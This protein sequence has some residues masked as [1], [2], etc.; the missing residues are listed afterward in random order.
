M[1]SFERVLKGS[2]IFLD[3][4]WF[5]IFIIIWDYY[6]FQSQKNTW[7]VIKNYFTTHN[8]HHTP[9]FFV[10]EKYNNH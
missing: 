1:E 3:K 8:T 4:G 2:Y 7:G 6:I 10:I 9:I 5:R